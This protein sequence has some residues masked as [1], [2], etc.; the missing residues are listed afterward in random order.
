MGVKRVDERGTNPFEA[1]TVARPVTTVLGVDGAKVGPRAKGWV[2]VQLDDG[3]LR[4]AELVRGAFDEVLDRAEDAGAAVVAVD[5]PI[6][7]DDPD[8]SLRDGR[9]LCDVEAKRFLGPRHASVF[10]VPP[11]KVLRQGDHEAARRLADEHGW[12]KPSAQL[13]NIRDRILDVEVHLQGRGRGQSQARGNGGSGERGGRGEPGER[14]DRGGRVLEVHP[15]V[16]FQ[17]LLSE[18]STTGEQPL[19]LEH[20]KKDPDGIYERL[21]LLHR[22][23][24]RPSRSIGGIGRAS[25]DDILDATV[26]A[27]SAHRLAEGLGGSIPDA[28]PRDPRTGR[29]VAIW[30]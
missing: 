26:C 30:H 3:K 20:S 9:R 21:D 18:T 27:W 28:P 29:P 14:G 11:P 22:A 16:S 24:L 17:V 12:I 4:Q 1:H 25:P 19:H 13:W 8:G 5:V 6:G 7:H 10:P 23:G 2:V 15:E